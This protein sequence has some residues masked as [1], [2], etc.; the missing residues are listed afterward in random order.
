M[1]KTTLCFFD[2]F[3]LDCKKNVVRQWYSPELIGTFKDDNFQACVYPSIAWCPEVGKYRIWYEGSPDLTFDAVRYLGVAESVDGVAWDLADIENKSDDICK[4]YKNVAYS[5]N[6][7]I[8]GTSVFRDEYETNPEWRYKAAGMTRTDKTRELPRGR[9]PLILSTSPDG[10]TWTEHANNPIYPFKSDTYNCIYYNPVS[11]E[12]NIILRAGY[13]DRRICLIK[14]KDLINWSEPKLIVHPD[15]EYSEGNYSIQLYTMSSYWNKGMFFGFMW[16]FHTS[17]IDEDLVKMNGF[18][19]TELMYSY[20]GEYWMHTTRKPL[21]EKPRTPEYGFNQVNFTSMTESAEKDRWLMIATISRMPHLSA[22]DYKEVY[23]RL[24]GNL[25]RINV[26]S[27]RKEGFC[28]LEACGT[29]GKII[30]KSFQMLKPGLTLNI[31]AETGAVRVAILDASGKPYEGF[32]YEDSIP[33]SC[34]G[35]E[36]APQWKERKLCELEGERF[37]L[38]LEMSSA[39]LYSISGTF[40]PYIACPQESISNPKQLMI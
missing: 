27:L 17:M 37:R 9:M 35:V 29:N 24:G 34:D 3:W 15:A 23:E 26:Y 5:G 31:G 30:T 12:Y 40:R 18:M 8:H 19:D 22:E 14:S 38:G 2:D 28:G 1:D 32:S 33:I 4:K 10:I 36:I 7:G 25:I 20:D 13:V 21:V 11:K 39:T 16:R 6:G